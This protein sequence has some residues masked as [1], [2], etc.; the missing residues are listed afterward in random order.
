MVAVDSDSEAAAARLRLAFELF[1][2]GVAMMGANLRREHPEWTPA[3]V[4]ARLVEWLRERPGPSMAT[5]RAARGTGP[6]SPREP[7]RVG[8]R[9]VAR[10]LERAGCRWALLGGL[11]VSVRAEPRFTRD[12]DLAVAVE[13]DRVVK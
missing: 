5:P 1:E 10:D 7:P 2:A 4:E 3:Q 9:Q 6:G 11:A 12:I 8:L 13:S